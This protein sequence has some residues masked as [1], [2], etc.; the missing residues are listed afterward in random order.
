VREKNLGLCDARVAAQLSRPSLLE[1]P[2]IRKKRKVMTGIFILI[3]G[4]VLF[5]RVFGWRLRNNRRARAV[6]PRSR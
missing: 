3:V 4:P 5:A 2:I 1:G 6:I